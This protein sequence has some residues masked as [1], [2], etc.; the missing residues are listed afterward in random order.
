M[1]PKKKQCLLTTFLPGSDSTPATPSCNANDFDESAVN[2]H[3]Y[4]KGSFYFHGLRQSEED[5]DIVY[6]RDCKTAGFRNDFAF[7]K[8]RPAKG[9]K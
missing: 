6:C 4:T 3:V 8:Q 2:I 1:P 5:P 7:G 9:W